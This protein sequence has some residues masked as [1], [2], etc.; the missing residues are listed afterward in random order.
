MADT[1]S[2]KWIYPPDMQDGGWDE[3]SG[4]RRV[5]VRF[6]GSS[7]GTGETDVRKVDLDLLKTPN[8]KVPQRTAVEHIQWHVFGLTCVLEWD[9][10]PH[11]EIIRINENGTESSGEMSWEKTGGYI[12]PGL[13]DATGDILLTTTN[14]TSG[15]S[16]DI[17][18]A[19][20]LKD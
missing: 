14:C 12:D 6:I 13:D 15:D 1:V 19:L 5:I 8:A 11:A 17:T 10:T 9:R 18:M 4:N 16:Y 2:V 7:D 20:R 3:K